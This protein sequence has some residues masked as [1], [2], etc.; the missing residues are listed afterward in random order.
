[1]SSLAAARADNFY[2]APDFNPDVHKSLNKVGTAPSCTSSPSAP[3]KAVLCICVPALCYRS[4][5]PCLL[6]SVYCECARQ[7]NLMQQ[8]VIS[9]DNY[10]AVT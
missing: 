6:S 9:R 10:Q 2:Y 3:C 4:A 8:R 5:V 7:E 1:M